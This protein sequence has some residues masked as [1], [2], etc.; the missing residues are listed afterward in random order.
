MGRRQ[1]HP[2]AEGE[3]GMGVG[4]PPLGREWRKQAR[5]QLHQRRG[6]STTSRGPRWAKARLSFCL[7]GFSSTGSDLLP[8]SCHAALHHPAEHQEAAH[9]RT[10]H[11]SFFFLLPCTRGPAGLGTQLAPSKI[12]LVG[13]LVSEWLFGGSFS[14]SAGL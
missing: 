1:S 14:S 8:A 5:T 3:V 11:F 6:K 12:V 2:P 13:R 7:A 9:P 10:G 4:A